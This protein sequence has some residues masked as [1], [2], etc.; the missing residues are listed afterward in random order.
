[1]I[2]TRLLRILTHPLSSLIVGVALLGAVVT[3][4][5]T[6]IPELVWSALALVAVQMLYLVR[7]RQQ[8]HSAVSRLNH[9]LEQGTALDDDTSNPLL[10]SFISHLNK[11]AG[12]GEGMNVM[13]GN[14]SENLASHAEQISI[15]ANVIAEQMAMQTERVEDI[16]QRIEQMQQVFKNS[17]ITA[18]Q[19]INVAS[20][21]EAEGN[22]GKLVMTEA[23]SSIAA[24]VDSVQTSGKRVRDLGE[25][26]ESIGGIINVIKG[27]AEQTNLLALNAAIEAARAGE[28][29]RGFAV[30]ADEVRSLASKT[31]HNAD[32]IQNII[33]DLVEKVTQTDKEISS[34]VELAQ[35][36]D[37][38]IEGVVMSYSEI[39]GCMLDVNKLGQELATTTKNE[40]AASNDIFSMIDEIKVIG[41]TTKV[42]ITNLA[43]ASAELGKLGEQLDVL[44]QGSAADADKESI[45]LF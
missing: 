11:N 26:S 36:S 33:S 19:T 30:V 2:K 27:V 16:H 6:G 38:H 44:T 17:I 31:Q 43:N 5:V 1:M 13:V 20:K 4:Y 8:S 34:S 14:V 9:A 39:V 40:N 23:M 37:E 3:G 45:D 29:G 42:N 21:S 24:L 32:E 18:E 41:D 7:Q 10:Q 12:K 35:Q 22:S 15:T 25:V 28:Q